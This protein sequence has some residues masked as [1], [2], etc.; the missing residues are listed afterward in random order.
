LTLGFGP[1]LGAGVFLQ[2]DETD[3]LG[4]FTA[5]IQAFNGV[6]QIGNF[7]ENSNS[8]GDPIFIGV[9]STSANITSIRLGV[10]SV[11]QNSNTNDFA[12]DTLFLTGPVPE[13]G[14]LIL[15]GIGLAILSG[16]LRRKSGCE[17]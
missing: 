13:P 5:Q 4:I 15:L 14:S 2:A 12:I 16:W 11:P 6:T 3:T 7:A 9:S 10:T 17:R 8:N 1:S